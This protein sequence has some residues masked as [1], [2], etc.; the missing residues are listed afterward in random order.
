MRKKWSP[1]GARTVD[2]PRKPVFL[3]SGP[4]GGAPADSVLLQRAKA[5]ERAAGRPLLYRNR[6]PVN[7]GV[8]GAVHR[9]RPGQCPAVF[10]ID[11]DDA[12]DPDVAGQLRVQ[13]D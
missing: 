5:V 3:T 2:L 1:I 7:P 8:F 9:G 10:D 4:A 6:L 12:P 11:K 13:R